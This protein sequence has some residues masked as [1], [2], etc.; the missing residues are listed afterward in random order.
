MNFMTPPS[1][2]IS[3]FL[4]ADNQLQICNGVDLNVKKGQITKDLGYS[5]VGSTLEANKAVTSLH[6]FRQSASIQ[7][8]LA[9]INNTAGTDLTLQY[10]NAGT[11]TVINTGTTWNAY[12]DAKVEMEDFIGYCFFVGYDSTD[13][14]WLPVASLTGTTFSTSTNVTSMPQAKYIKRYRD[15]LYLGNCYYSAAA[16]PYRV[17][18]S[19]VPSAGSIT[20]TPA[21]DFI[22]VDFSEQI[23]GLGENWDRLMVFTEFSAY[24]YDQD[25]KKK[26]WDIGCINGRTIQ[27]YGPYMIWANKYN[28]WASTSGRP[29]PI[30]GDIAEFIKNS[31][32][33]RW[34]AAVVDDNYYLYLGATESNG[35]AYTNCMAIFNMELGFWRIRE[36][37]DNV[38]SLARYTSGSD[39]RLYMG[40]ADGMV[41]DK[42]K[43]K[44]ATLVYTD[45]TKPILAH[46]RTKAYDFGDPSIDKTIKKIVAYAEYAQGLTLRFRIFNKNQ[47]AVMPFVDIGKLEQ[48]INEFDRKITGN[49]IQFEGKEYSG[50]QAFKFYGLSVEVI[51]DSNL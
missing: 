16:Y 49:F 28:V 12:E 37:Y 43:R 19:S 6:N 10:N 27:N 26:V 48:V 34:Q 41:H 18:F 38:T 3:P 11:W 15:R 24:M 42:C 50:R 29:T 4:L 45:D 22:D 40:V 32:P 33:S 46:F 44:D 13:N 7:K 8:I 35:R 36:L 5:K 9:T 30:G 1:G 31:T 21:S 23:T 17:Y 39:D 14:V 51:G 20:W 2:E 47:E 25:T